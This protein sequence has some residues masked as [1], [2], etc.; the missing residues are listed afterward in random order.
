[1]RGADA[2][3]ATGG[4]RWRARREASLL[5]LCK[6]SN[7]KKAHPSPLAPT[8]SPL[9]SVSP[10][11]ILGRHIPVPSQDAARPARRPAGLPTVATAADGAPSQGPKPKRWHLRSLILRCCCCLRFRFGLWGPAASAPSMKN[12]QQQHAPAPSSPTTTKRKTQS[13]NRNYSSTCRRSGPGRFNSFRCNERRCIPNNRAAA[14]MF[15]S[16]SASAC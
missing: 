12:R 6:G 7:Q 11:G 14:E 16:V 4:L 1:M 13:E 2:R 3:V 8:A 9:G 5:C 10:V 15:P